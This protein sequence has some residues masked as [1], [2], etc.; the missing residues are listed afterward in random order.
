MVLSSFQDCLINKG[1]RYTIGDGS[2]IRIGM[3]NVVDSHHPWPLNTDERYKEM[4]LDNL[5]YFN[6]SSYSWDD[7]KIT[8]FVDPS[9]HDYLRRSYL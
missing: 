2:S 1:T 8:Q 4:S 9:D 5:L 6:G 7:S 3:D